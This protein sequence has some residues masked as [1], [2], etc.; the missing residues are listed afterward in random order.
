MYK[1][2]CVHQLL[3]CTTVKHHTSGRNTIQNTFL[4]QTSQKCSFSCAVCKSPLF[5]TANSCCSSISLSCQEVLVLSITAASP[6]NRGGMRTC[7]ALT[8]LIRAHSA[9]HKQALLPTQI[10]TDWEGRKKGRR[11]NLEGRVHIKAIPM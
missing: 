10:G 4:D 8:C 11:T 5:S 1:L 6:V 7:S 2:Q 3:Y 9:T